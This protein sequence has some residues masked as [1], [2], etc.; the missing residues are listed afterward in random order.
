MT[1]ANTVYSD[2]KIC[3]ITFKV[4]PSASGSTTIN[5]NTIKGTTSAGESLVAADISKTVTITDDEPTPNPK[6]SDATLKGL[7]VSSGSLSPAFNPSTESYK[8]SVGNDVTKIDV[9]ALTNDP[10][11]KVSISGNNNLSVGKNNII[12]QV[13]AEDGSKKTYTI[14]VTRAGKTSTYT[15]TTKSSNANLKSINGID[16]LNFDPNKT[17]YDVEVP[18][19]TTNISVTAVP[20]SSKATTSISNGKLSDLKVGETKTVTIAVK[21]ED[22]TIKVYT[23]NVKRSQYKSETDLDK[24]SVDDK[25]LTP[26]ANGEYNITVS[27]DKK[28]VLVSAI[29][30]SKD[31]TVKIIGNKNLKS[32]NNKVIVQVTDKN[33]FTKSYIVNVQRQQELSFFR[34][35]D[36]YW[37]LFLLL[38]FLI[39]LILLYYYHKNK[40]YLAALNDQEEEIHER[41]T[42]N[43]APTNIDNKVYISYNSNNSIG[44]VDN[45]ARDSLQ[46]NVDR[47]LNDSSI[48]EVERTVSYVKEGV[49]DIER[50]YEIKEK[51]RKK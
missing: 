46:T 14:E 5:I 32:G 44:Y 30:K 29:P 41:L 43:Y 40:K 1:P 10:N 9:S 36:K 26:G 47:L 15:P 24:L 20:E 35:V 19:E 12:V 17:S 13:T 37:Y 42:E 33:G 38:P 45:D 21:A 16:G 25:D 23:I 50:E 4:L 7:T 11:A 31:A 39:M 22:G 49:D 6:S 51:L 8:V 34:F 28:S 48:P 27:S 3:N 18:F 2:S